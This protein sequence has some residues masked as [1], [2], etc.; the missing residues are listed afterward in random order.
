MPE[1]APLVLIPGLLC[2]GALWRHQTEYLADVASVTVADVTH[3][4]A[5]AA[6]AESVLRQAPPGRFSLAGLSM[7]GYVALEIMR[8]APE[9]VAH[10]ALLD[11]SAR[12]DSDET[13]ARRTAMIEQSEQGDFKGVTSRLIGQFIHPDR[14]GD[15]VLTHAVT[16]MTARVGKDAF[17]RQQRAIMGR[18]DSRARLG[19]I[20]V[21]TLVLVGREDG[22]TPLELHEE[23]AARIPRAKLVIVEH[24]GHLTTMERPEAVTA[25]LRYWLQG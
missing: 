12:P 10:L 24:S 7:G 1:R 6:M 17:A 22:L 11:T 2:D 13:R 16:E 5:M 4:T 20:R 3:E 21:P 15:L 23:L 25:V 18:P 9:R 14:L 19:E 8:K